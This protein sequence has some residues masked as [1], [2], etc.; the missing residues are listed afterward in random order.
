LTFVHETP[1][2]ELFGVLPR[3]KMVMLCFPD[4]VTVG[5]SLA[6]ASRQ[7]QTNL[8]KVYGLWARGGKSR[9]AR[10]S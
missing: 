3:A 9:A 4:A 10:K 5:R 1:K 6:A 8:R 7:C 2:T